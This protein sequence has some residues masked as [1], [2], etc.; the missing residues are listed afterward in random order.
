M[1]QKVPATY[2]ALEDVINHVAVERRLNCLDPV[3]NT[4]QYR[5]V[6]TTE[7]QQRYNRTFRDWA[8][9]HQA[10]LF[11]HDNGVLLHY[12]DATL[13]DL[14]FLDPQWLCDMLAHVV[15]IRE[16]NPFARTGVMKLD[17]LKH[18]FKASNIGPMDTRGYIVNLL[19]KFE[20]ALTW[21]SRTLLIPSLLPSEEDIHMAQLHPGHHPLVKIKVP[22]R[23]R[24]WAVRNKKITVSPK[25]VLYK[26]CSGKFE[27]S[28][29]S[30][31]L[32]SPAEELLPEVRYQLTSKSSEK[33]V[34]RLL[35]M[36]Y[37]PSGFWSRLMSRILADD[38]IVDIV[39][40]FFVLPKE[41]SLV[42]HMYKGNS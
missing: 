27:M 42:L 35:L 17:D 30:T 11:L 4:E 16:I 8:E 38:S 6:V 2:L 20:V 1:E 25:S 5:A 21:D 22:L 10:T 18:I 9:L 37:F 28:L 33:S 40:S 31:S 12:D 39:R 19:N 13:K 7:M 26:E 41:V 15:T 23:S 32:T 24:G 34:T 29:P 14:Y 36:S 3:L